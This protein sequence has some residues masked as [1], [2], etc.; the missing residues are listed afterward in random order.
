[1]NADTIDIDLEIHEKFTAYS[2]FMP[3]VQIRVYLADVWD[4]YAASRI[5]GM[6]FYV[7]HGINGERSEIFSSLEELNKRLYDEAYLD[8]HCADMTW[9]LGEPD[10]REYEEFIKELVKNNPEAYL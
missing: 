6:I 9:L 4:S 3:P 8:W 7:V 10:T 5:G 1:M 2:E